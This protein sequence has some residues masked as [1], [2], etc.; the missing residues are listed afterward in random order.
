M[1]RFLFTGQIPHLRSRLDI[2]EVMR[3]GL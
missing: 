1:N 2:A 3:L